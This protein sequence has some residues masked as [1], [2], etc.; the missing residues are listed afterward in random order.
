MLHKKYQNVLLLVFG[1]LCASITVASVAPDLNVADVAVQDQSNGALQK[2]LPAAFN[3]VLVKMSGN[4]NIASAPAVA[5]AKPQL[6]SLLMDYSYHQNSGAT[7]VTVT[8]D[9]KAVIKFMRD[10]GLPV[11][12]EDRPQTLIWL[13]VNDGQSKHVL[14]SADQDS[15]TTQLQQ[16]AKQ[17]GL[18]ILLPTMDLSDQDFINQDDTKTFDQQKLQAAQQRYAVNAV[19]AGNLQSSGA[20]QWQ[21][22]FLLLLNGQPFSWNNDATSAEDSVQRAVDYAT[23]LM[24]NQLAV[25]DNKAQQNSVVLNIVGI[26]DLQQY[27]LAIAYVRKLAPVTQVTVKDMSGDSV[28]LIVN[29][30]GAQELIDALNQSPVLQAVSQPADQT[31]SAELFYRWNQTS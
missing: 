20:N 27:R 29:T 15:L 5:S 23:N 2:V 19:L 21:G 26:Q 8:F 7:F 9:K 30:A 17:R 10:A 4:P 16:A 18:P 6:S 12:N 14:G 11:W 13:T 24:A 28:Q 31:N 22:Q 25:T 1:L 3:Q